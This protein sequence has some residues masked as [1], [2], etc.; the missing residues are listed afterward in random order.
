MR[1]PS[2]AHTHCEP[3]MPPEPNKTTILLLA[4]NPVDTGALRLS[5]EV[6]GIQ[7]AFERA[8]NRDSF[9]L[10]SRWAVTIDDLA[11]ALQEFEDGPLILHFAGHGE[12]GAIYLQ[13]EDGKA[14]AVTGEALR[15]FLA[16]F[17][18]IQ[19]VVLNACY[20]DELADALAAAVPCVIGMAVAVGDA[21][22]IDFSVAFYDGVGKSTDYKRAFDLAVGRLKLKNTLDAVRPVYKPGKMPPL[23]PAPNGRAQGEGGT[24]A[25]FTPSGDP[26]Y[27]R[28]VVPKLTTI[29]GPQHGQLAEALAD[30]F[31]EQSLRQM[32]K[33][34]LNQTLPN[35]VGGGTFGAVTFNLVD[36]AKRSG[37]LTELIQ[38]AVDTQPRNQKLR[39]FA[40]SVGAKEA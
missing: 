28:L 24:D 2:A 29:T 1:A 4:A 20:S 8:K 35:I 11:H 14:V 23:P 7:K 34:K 21:L 15:D 3:I 12:D 6:K 36:W 39:D 13:G 18:T 30:A 5:D 40:V 37:Y 22:A 38:G 19:C 32:V 10:H 31:D 17:P 9:S 25:A 27:P 26:A 16:L 33:V